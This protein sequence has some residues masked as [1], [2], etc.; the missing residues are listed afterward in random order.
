[1]SADDDRSPAGATALGDAAP[2]AQRQAMERFLAEVEKRAFQLAWLALRHEDDALDAVQDAM[3]QLCRRYAERPADEWRPLFFRILVNKV[4]DQRRRRT[5]RGRWLA[6][7]TQG[8]PADAEEAVPDVLDSTPDTLL[9]PTRRLEGEGA[10]RAV[11]AA[12]QALPPRQQQA[13]LLRNVE[14]LDVAGTALA[15]GCSEG[16]VKTHYFRALQ[17]LRLAVGEDMP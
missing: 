6:W 10:L 1:M 17:A 15:M 7:W 13:F 4:Q 3:L 2:G 14:G 16:S 9:E 11:A 5:V 12:V 8:Q